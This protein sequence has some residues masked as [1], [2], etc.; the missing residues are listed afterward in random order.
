MKKVFA[1]PLALSAALVFG[2]IG[3]SDSN[4]R[5]KIASPVSQSG[6]GEVYSINTVSFPSRDDV[7]V[8]GLVGRF[9]DGLKHPVVIM[10]HDVDP[11]QHDKFDWLFFFEQLLEAGYMPLSIDL[12]GHGDTPLP[13]DDRDEELVGLLTIGDVEKSYFDVEAALLWLRNRDDVD[14]DRVAIIGDGGGGNVAYVSTGA[15]PQQVKTAVALSP[16]LLAQN[17][18]GT[19]GPIVIGN[20]V[21]PFTPH[22]I[23]FMVGEQDFLQVSQ[24][25]SVAYAGFATT[26]LDLT[27]DPKGLAIIPGSAN[28]GLDLLGEPA[29]LQLLL[30]WLADNL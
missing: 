26:M 12:R 27:T 23:L 9:D 20:G 6:D 2:T 15:F 5:P 28:H 14:L 19:L 11:S 10:V 30:D 8:S 24:T 17:E 13:I 18:D 16:G 4:S 25:Q 3:C 22:S 1:L 21:T 29:S 7:A